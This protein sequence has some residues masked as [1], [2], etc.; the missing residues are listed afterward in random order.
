[1][2]ISISKILG[3]GT[4]PQDLIQTLQEA[5]DKKIENVR[6]DLQVSIREEFAQR[7]EHDKEGL[8][9]A[10]N[11][12][13]TEVATKHA[14]ENAKSIKEFADARNAFRTAKKSLNEKFKQKL[15]ENTAVSRELVFKKLSEEVV[16]L[17]KEK[18]KLVDAKLAASD[19]L[20]E[21]KKEMQDEM[22]KRVKKMDE[23]VI[24]QVQKELSELNEDHKALIETRVKLVTESRTK[25]RE[26]TS[27]FV[28]EAAKKVEKVINETLKSEMTQ[29][30]EDLERNRQ[31]MFG[32]R[33]FEAVAAEFL[34][35]HLNEDSEINK[36]QT[37]LESREK[38]MKQLKSKLDEAVKVS[39]QS[40]RKVKIAEDRATRNKIMTELLGNIRGD[41]RTVME[42]MLDNVK[43]EA[44]RET[45]NRLLPVVI[46][47]KQ[48]T[49]VVTQTR[50]LVENKPVSNTNIVTGDR[51]NIL[52]EDTQKPINDDS[53]EII[54]LAG[55]YK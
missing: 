55:I 42:G 50:K 30:H 38:E 1:M 7:Y 35:S 37:V 52:T 28:K 8:I 44:L 45:F 54:R 6:N 31:N 18:K 13:L 5:F 11:S 25:L 41:K 2:D 43:T 27:N 36:L 48:K 33:I 4:L 21:A 46:N 19:E 20:E 10:M 24:R 26:T 16:K 47:E 3:E 9:E 22:K 32:R 53:A 14:E 12:M 17:R 39:E 29:L 34:T 49:P 15:E 40:M 23:F 51:N